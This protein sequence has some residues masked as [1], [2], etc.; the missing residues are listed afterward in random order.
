MWLVAVAGTAILALIIAFNLRER[1][2][3]MGILLSLGEK[4]HKLLGQHLVEVVGCAVLAIG[5]AAAGS[6]FV[7]QG[8]GDQLLSGQV[9]SARNS[10]AD[11][12]PGQDLTD[13]TGG[14]N[15]EDTPEAEPIDTIDIELGADDIGAVGAT[16]LG[17]AALATLVPGIR[18]LRL[19]PRDILTKGD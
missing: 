3:E 7:A 17:I 16:G 15:K 10:A 13:P 1:R 9:S 8:I 2:K 4:K 14:A 12:G 6:Q 5:F 11:Q 18:V 19:N